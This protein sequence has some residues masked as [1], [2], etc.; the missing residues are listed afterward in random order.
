MTFTSVESCHVHAMLFLVLPPC[1]APFSGG[2]VGFLWREGANTERGLCS[3]RWLT[4]LFVVGFSSSQMYAI[5]LEYCAT[6]FGVKVYARKRI[7]Q[8]Y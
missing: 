7:L 5:L 3:M 6:L 8:D 4:K 1:R 2:C